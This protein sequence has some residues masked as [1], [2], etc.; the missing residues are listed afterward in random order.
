MALPGHI[1]RQLLA[2]LWPRRA[3]KVRRERNVITPQDP[4]TT[5]NGQLPKHDS[6]K[7]NETESFPA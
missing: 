4:G 2:C 5:R 3:V 1:V 7:S 6:W